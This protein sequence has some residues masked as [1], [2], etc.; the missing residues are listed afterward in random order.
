[1]LVDE[2]NNSDE[3]LQQAG[4]GV[5]NYFVNGMASEQLIAA[6][7]MREQIK[8][9]DQRCKDLLPRILAIRTEVHSVFNMSP[10]QIAE[11]NK[12]F[13]EAS[14]SAFAPT[15]TSGLTP[16]SLFGLMFEQKCHIVSSYV[17]SSKEVRPKS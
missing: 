14:S 3:G 9:R 13:A 6:P 7:T 11:D 12:T 16:I 8:S 5:K 10:A 2:L 17:K 15:P 4:Y 1:M